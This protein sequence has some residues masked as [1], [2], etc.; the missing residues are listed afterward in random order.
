MLL[1][2]STGRNDI[3]RLKLRLV[4]PNIL[5]KY[6]EAGTEGTLPPN[7]HEIFLTVFTHKARSERRHPM[8]TDLFYK[9]SSESGNILSSFSTP[10]PPLCM[11]WWVIGV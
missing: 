5:W 4:C 1:T 7:R 2:V 6:R 10:M 8:T 3:D 9:T 11:T